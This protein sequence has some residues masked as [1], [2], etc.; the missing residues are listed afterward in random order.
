VDFDL[1]VTAWTK[2]RIACLA[3]PSFHE[4]STSVAPAARAWLLAA[5]IRAG[6]LASRQAA[7]SR[8][9]RDIIAASMP[10]FIYAS[11][12]SSCLAVSNARGWRLINRPAFA[13]VMR[14]C[15]RGKAGP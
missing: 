4:A 12:W 9:C 15:H 13:R 6:M 3:G 2:S 5:M 10:D 1:S 14:D 8:V 11:P 7:S